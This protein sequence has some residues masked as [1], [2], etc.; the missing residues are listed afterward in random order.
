MKVLVV[1]V[2][3]VSMANVSIG[4]CAA[5]CNSQGLN[6]CAGALFNFIPPST[7]CCSKLKQ[8][9]PCMCQY[10]KDPHLHNFIAS[11]NAKNIAQKCGTPL[12][13]C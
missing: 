8:Q 6:V 7:S 13:N 2:V 11:P 4:G 3:M 9:A 5:S 12:P 10:S 1:V